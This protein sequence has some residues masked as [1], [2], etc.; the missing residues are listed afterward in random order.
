[1]EPEHSE[2]VM[3]EGAIQDNAIR[4]LKKI[5]GE[6]GA[7]PARVSLAQSPRGPPVGARSLLRSLAR[8]SAFSSKHREGEAPEVEHRPHTGG[9]R[10]EVA[11]PED[12]VAPCVALGVLVAAA[13][14]V[15]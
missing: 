5:E 4:R 7:A 15:A 10:V 1:M 11:H 13:C 12:G 8:G 2:E 9:R 14:R 3:L 6:L